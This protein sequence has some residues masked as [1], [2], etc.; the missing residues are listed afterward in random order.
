MA[1]RVPYYNL[2]QIITGR[3]TPGNDFVLPDGTDYIGEYHILPTLQ[4]FTGSRPFADSVELFEK[5]ISISADTLKYN[6]IRDIDASQYI[7]PILYYPNPN[8]DDYKRGIIERYFVQKR[9]NPSNT[10]LEINGQQYNSINTRGKPGINGVI[11]NKLM[12]QWRISRIP[13]SDVM[14]LNKETLI[15]SEPLFPGIGIYINNVTEFYT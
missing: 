13:K 10:I 1:V 12:I 5:R 14:Y 7:M 8:V 9:N 3:Y 6:Q 15:R 2:H 11:W 4:K